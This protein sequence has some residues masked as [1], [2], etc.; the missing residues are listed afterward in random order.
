MCIR[1]SIQGNV[2][3]DNSKK[4]L[5]TVLQYGLSVV[6]SEVFVTI[7]KTLR[8]AKIESELVAKRNSYAQF[9]MM[10]SVTKAVRRLSLKFING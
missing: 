3:R 9:P 6:R 4:D 2:V 5:Q 7:M 1:Y 10:S 8:A